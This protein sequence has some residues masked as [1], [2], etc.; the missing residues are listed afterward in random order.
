MARARTLHVRTEDLNYEPQFKAIKQKGTRMPERP[1]ARLG[2]RGRDDRG[3]CAMKMQA[4]GG[5]QRVMAKSLFV[6]LR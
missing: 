5:M 3:A 6:K 4:A 2:K 1:G